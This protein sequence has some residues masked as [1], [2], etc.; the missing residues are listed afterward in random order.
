MELYFSTFIDD[1]SKKT[2]VNNL[3]SKS[4][5]IE[6]FVDLKALVENQTNKRIMILWTDNGTDYVN[7]DFKTYSTNM[8]DISG[9]ATNV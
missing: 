3:T 8:S 6:T 9:F 2:F 1:H 5:V 4:E 7:N